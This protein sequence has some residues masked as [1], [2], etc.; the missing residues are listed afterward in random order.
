MVKLG[1]IQKL[2]YPAILN[3]IFEDSEVAWDNI[4]K[5]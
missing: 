4:Q 1:Y 5:Q 3:S 2:K